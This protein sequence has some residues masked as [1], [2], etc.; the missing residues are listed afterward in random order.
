M[1]V[2]DVLQEQLDLLVG[3]DVADVLRVAAQLAEREADHL[4]ARDG[5][6]PAVAGLIAASIWMRRP[7]TG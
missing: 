4:V 7:D 2:G 5:G 1:A 3:N 6:S